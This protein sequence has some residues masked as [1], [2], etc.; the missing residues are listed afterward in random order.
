MLSLSKCSLI[1]CGGLFPNLTNGYIIIEIKPWYVDLTGIRE[2][3]YLMTFMQE[4]LHLVLWR[5]KGKTLIWCLPVHPLVKHNLDPFS[6]SMEYLLRAKIGKLDV[7][8]REFHPIISCLNAT[9]WWRSQTRGHKT[10]I[11]RL[12]R[13]SC[14]VMVTN[15]VFSLS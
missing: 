5:E 13:V 8:T 12:I 10:D 4:M 3:F 15:P 1:I 6:T 2:C 11:I 14:K 9:K 7:I